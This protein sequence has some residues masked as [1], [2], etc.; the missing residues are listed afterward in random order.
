MELFN[1]EPN[2][3]LEQR[4]AKLE[5]ENQAL[6]QLVITSNLQLSDLK[7]LCTDLKLEVTILKEGANL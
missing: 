7:T 3:D 2:L 4:V 1:A 5:K 6:K